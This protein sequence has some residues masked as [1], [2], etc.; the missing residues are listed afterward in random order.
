[1]RRRGLLVTAIV[2]ALGVTLGAAPTPA[3]NQASQVE[4]K[5]VLVRDNFFEAR[6]V[7]IHKGD[8]VTWVWRGDNSHNVT[9]TKVPKG[10]SKRG[11][12]T[13]QEGRFSRRF[14]TRGLYKYICTNHAGMRG[15]I[16]VEYQQSLIPTPK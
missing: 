15:S 2:V 9:F 10:A 16:D 7:S 3:D 6:S 14:R 13:R 11:A 8:R 12:S 5:R 1:M 4:R